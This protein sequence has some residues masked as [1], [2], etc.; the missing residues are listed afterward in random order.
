MR[1]C[2][3]SHYF[4]RCLHGAPLPFLDKATCSIYATITSCLGFICSSGVF[5]QK[6]DECLLKKNVPCILHAWV[7]SAGAFWLLLRGCFQADAKKTKEQLVMW[8]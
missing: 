8:N 6:N 7:L 2:V 1:A 3:V 5:D 4:L